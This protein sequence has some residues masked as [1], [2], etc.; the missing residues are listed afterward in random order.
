MQGLAVQSSKWLEYQPNAILPTVSASDVPSRLAANLR[1]LRESRSLTQQQ[2]AKLAGLPRP[3]WATLESGSANPTLAVVLRAAAALQVSVEELIGPPRAT[4]TLYRAEAL[5]VR[6]RG[7]VAVRELLPEKIPGLDI[8]RLEI[9]RDAVLNGIPH[10]P[11][12]REYLSCER[13]RIELTAEGE[14]FSLG[15]GDVVVFRG[16]QRHSYHNPG[17]EVAVGYSV[18]TLA[19]PST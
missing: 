2:A 18:V 16:D 6:R 3:T 19:P 7:L 17:S 13:G 1:Q 11:G 9:P 8:E 4:G 10:T 5:R 15:P 12:T 14:T